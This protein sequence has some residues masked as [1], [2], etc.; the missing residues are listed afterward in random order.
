MPLTVHQPSTSKGKACR[1]E[2]YKI[3]AVIITGC[4]EEPTAPPTSDNANGQRFEVGDD[5]SRGSRVRATLVKQ[6]EATQPRP[7]QTCNPSSKQTRLLLPGL[8]LQGC[9]WPT[10]APRKPSVNTTRRGTH[11]ASRRSRRSRSNTGSKKTVNNAPPPSS[12][13]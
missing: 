10:P 4:G 11:R 2:N 9:L 13:T 5:E 3:I 1:R 6:K 8:T 7:K 12:V